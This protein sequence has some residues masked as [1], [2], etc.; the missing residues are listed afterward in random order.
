MTDNR[1]PEQILTGIADDLKP[2]VDRLVTELGRDQV[3]KNIE[4]SL[5]RLEAGRVQRI[6]DYL[7][8]SDKTPSEGRK[9]VKYVLEYY[10]DYSRFVY[11]GLANKAWLLLR[12]DYTDEVRDWH[13]LV[14][15]AQAAIGK[16]DPTTVERLNVLADLLRASIA[17]AE[18]ERSRSAKP[19]EQAQ[20]SEDASTRS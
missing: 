10:P 9:A 19:P 20:A 16:R 2:E 11:V 4:S 15:S 3:I 12:A 13:A 1:T 17:D 14:R 5:A 7:N 8:M 6:S 18:I